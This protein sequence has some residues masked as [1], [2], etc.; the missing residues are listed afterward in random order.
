L[1]PALTFVDSLSTLEGEWH[2]LEAKRVK[3]KRK[4]EAAESESTEMLRP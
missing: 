3:K 4:A 1:I 2:E